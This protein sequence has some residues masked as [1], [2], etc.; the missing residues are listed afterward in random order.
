MNIAEEVAHGEVRKKK[1]VLQPREVLLFPN[2]PKP[3]PRPGPVDPLPP[4]A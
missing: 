4:A 2:P 3:R 1:E